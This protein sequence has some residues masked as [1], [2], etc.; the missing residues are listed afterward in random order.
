MRWVVALAAVAVALGLRWALEPWLGEQVPFITI[1]GVVIAAAAVLL[2]P[3]MMRA[4]LRSDFEHLDLLKTWPARAADVI[5]GEMAWPIAVV[6]AIA[7]GSLLIAAAFSGTALPETALLDRWS[8]ALALREIC[9]SPGPPSANA[10]PG[11]LTI[12]STLARAYLSSNFRPIT[13]SPSGLSGQT[14]AFR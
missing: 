3:Q 7:C 9:M 2:G 11:T 1:F 14:S 8:V 10:I 5:R 12:S 6:S 4:D 13:S